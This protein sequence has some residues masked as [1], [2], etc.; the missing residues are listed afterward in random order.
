[1]DSATRSLVRQ[2][3]GNRCEYCLI[4]QAHYESALHV[5]HIVA[6][7]HHGADDPENLALACNHCNLHKGPNLALR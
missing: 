3:A 1:M 2:R 7:Q 5:E 4:R 6:K